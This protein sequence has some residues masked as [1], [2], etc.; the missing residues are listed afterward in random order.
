[1]PRGII[2]RVG[3]R[4]ADAYRAVRELA[5]RE[6]RHLLNEILQIRGLMALLMKQRNLGRW[7]DEDRDELKVHLRRL[8]KLSPYLIL[9]VMPGSFALLPVLAWWLDRRRTRGRSPAM[10]ETRP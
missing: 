10:N 6:K 8:S 1:M 3:N 2:T 4:G 9:L 5:A 7:S